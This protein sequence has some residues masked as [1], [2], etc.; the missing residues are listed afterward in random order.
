MHD[1][2]SGR[3]VSAHEYHNIACANGKNFIASWLNVENP[4]H[5]LSNIYGAVGTSATAPASTDT[6]L[7]AELA[8]VVLGTNSRSSNIV[9]F[10][11][12]FNTS[13]GNGTWAEAGLFLNATSATN[14]GS[15]LSHL[16]VS[17]AKT[18]LV[19]ATLQ[20]AISIG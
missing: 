20:I 1:A 2:A 9:T 8:R 17:E 3:L 6:Q 7:G 15:L 18:S 12:F 16:A 19:T 13:S 5:T 14:N 10:S 11:F 4:S